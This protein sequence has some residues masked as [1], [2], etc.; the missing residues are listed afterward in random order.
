MKGLGK[1]IQFG[2]DEG[3]FH[4][5]TS[6]GNG[7]FYCTGW[8]GVCQEKSKKKRNFCKQRFFFFFLNRVISEGHNFKNKNVF[9]EGETKTICC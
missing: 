6:L 3:A 8:D 9:Y 4:G 2:G 1:A 5:K 7:C